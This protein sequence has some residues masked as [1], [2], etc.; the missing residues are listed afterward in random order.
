MR[1]DWIADR[2]PNAGRV[3]DV[4]FAGEK[5]SAVHERL[6][7]RS[8]HVALIGVDLNVGRLRAL[9]LPMTLGGDVSALPFG[10]ATF[11]AVIAGELLEH[12]D[13]PDAAL[14]E[15]AR[16]L[17]PG[18]R[19]VI[20]TPNPYELQRWLRHWV[21]AADPSSP[22]NVRRFLGNA[23]HEGFV[24]PVSFCR[25]LRRHNLDAIELRTIKF[26]LPLLGR[27]LRQSAIIPGNFFPANRLG[28]YLCIV[29][30]KQSSD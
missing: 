12:L 23:D 14:P 25:S 24:E 5:S 30:I 26:H 19:L 21:F 1:A 18:G 11:D 15:F 3:L 28:A 8:P 10:D 2:L 9:Q 29:A 16:V 13:S 20:T 7:A 17:R 4:G 27:L 22:E 6:R